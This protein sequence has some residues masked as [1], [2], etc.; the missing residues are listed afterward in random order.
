[1]TLSLQTVKLDSN[2]HK[3]DECQ[4]CREEEETTVNMFLNV[5]DKRK[6]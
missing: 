1:M 6:L 2:Y 3:T 5:V 4:V